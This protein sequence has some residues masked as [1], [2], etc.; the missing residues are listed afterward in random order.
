MSTIRGAKL[1]Y[2]DVLDTDLFTCHEEGIEP[3]LPCS[4][5]FSLP[6]NPILHQSLND[7]IVG[8]LEQNLENI[9][10]R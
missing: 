7:F 2:H 5:R 1:A 9:V 6:V 3:S 4:G 8:L 10:H